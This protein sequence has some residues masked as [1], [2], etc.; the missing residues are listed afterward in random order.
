MKV[1]F[2]HGRPARLSEV[3]DDGAVRRLNISVLFLV[4][5]YG[6]VLRDAISG[7]RGA[8]DAV[9]GGHTGVLRAAFN[10]EFASRVLHAALE[11]IK[12]ILVEFEGFVKETEKKI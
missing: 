1:R 3:V 9:T 11:I 5:G 4:L 2:C 12:K 8:E 7:G 10:V 6:F